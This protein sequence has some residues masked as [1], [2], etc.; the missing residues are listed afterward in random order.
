MLLVR[1]EDARTASNDLGIGGSRC[2][3]KVRERAAG[4]GG[5]TSE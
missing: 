4:R 5:V 1:Q 2:H 3:D